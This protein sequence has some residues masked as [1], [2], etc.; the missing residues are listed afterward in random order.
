MDFK[1]VK[2][3][4]ESIA[5]TYKPAIFFLFFVGKDGDWLKLAGG[6]Y[7]PVSLSLSQVDFRGSTSTS[8]ASAWRSTVENRAGVKG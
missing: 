1:G 3:Y 2:I 4:P 5:K 6:V 8:V 7:F